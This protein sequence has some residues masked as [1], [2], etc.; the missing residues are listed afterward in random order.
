MNENPILLARIF[1]FFHLFSTP[2]FSPVLLTTY[3][4]LLPTTYLPLLPT[5]YQPLPPHSIARAPQT[6]SGNELGAWSRLGAGASLDELGAGLERER[7]WNEL[8]AWNGWSIAGAWNG[9][10]HSCRRL[11]F[12]AVELLQRRSTLRSR[13]SAAPRCGACCSGPFLA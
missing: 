12:Y 3:L 4:P 2:K 5:T 6:L 1:F 7:A 13:C 8:G 9:L 11:F 10:E